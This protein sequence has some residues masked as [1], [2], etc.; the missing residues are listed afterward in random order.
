MRTGAARPLAE[1]LAAPASMHA[2]FMAFTRLA[3]Q[4]FGGVLPV[5]Q[6]E[7]VER[8]RWLSREQF[9]EMLSVA[10]VLPGPNI[11]NLAL[12]IGDRFF[13]WR[14][15]VVAVG[16]ILL[17]P[18]GVVLVLA[19]LAAQLRSQPM[20]AGA[21]RGMGVVAAGLVLSTAVRLGSG[22]RKNALGP[23]PCAVIVVVTALAVGGLRWPL[24]WVVLGTG[25]PS[26][27]LAWWR[28]PR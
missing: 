11:V 9:L 12:M 26:I 13:G 21:L 15:G 4:G 20:V 14:G 7:I 24:I 5:A 25:L 22:L 8:Q 23:W 3:L 17:A 10:Q 6:R 2:M 1:G 28:V 27:A 16:G 19:L 18:L